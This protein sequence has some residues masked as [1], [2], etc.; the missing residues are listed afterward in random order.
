MAIDKYKYF[1]KMLYCM[2]RNKTENNK[3]RIYFT[4]FHGS[5]GD[6]Y[7]NYHFIL[8]KKPQSAP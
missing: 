4:Q 8:E 3:R 1:R 6:S 5:F 7:P 2:H